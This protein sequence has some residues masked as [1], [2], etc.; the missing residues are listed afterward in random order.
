M[1]ML[2]ILFEKND[3]KI[4]LNDEIL[5]KQ[6]ILDSNEIEEDNDKRKVKRKGF[7]E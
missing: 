1:S 5:Q 2:E 6:S 4:K 7:N 3:S